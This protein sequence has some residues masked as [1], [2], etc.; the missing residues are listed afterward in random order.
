MI[1]PKPKELK[2]I[3]MQGVYCNLINDTAR[4]TADLSDFDPT[5]YGVHEEASI[6]LNDI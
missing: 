6:L 1:N 2:Q 3:W 4:D 5:N